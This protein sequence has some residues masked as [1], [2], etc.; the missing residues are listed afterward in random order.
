MAAP[1]HDYTIQGDYTVT[2]VVT[3]PTGKTGSATQLIEATNISIDGLSVQYKC[4]DQSSSSG[5]VRAEYRIVNNSNQNLPIN[6]FKIRYWFTKDGAT[7]QN[8]FC[9]Y[10]QVGSGNISGSF[11]NMSPTTVNADNYLE[12]SISGTSTLNA[13]SNSGQIQTRF[14]KSDWQAYTQTNDYS[15]DATALSFTENTKVTLY[16]DGELVFGEE[17]GAVGNNAPVAVISPSVLSGIAPL[18]VTFN[19]SGSS[20][21]DSDPITYLW[22]SGETTSG[23]S[24]TYTTAGTYNVSLTVSDG[25]LTNQTSVSVVVTSVPV[26]VTGVSVNPI[27]LN[28]TPGQ[29]GSVIATV[30]PANA[31]N[32]TVVWTS[33]NTAAATVNQ[34]GVVTAV[35]NGNAIITVTT[36]DGGF[37]ATCNVLVETQIV[38][39]T[40][41]TVNPSSASI[42]EGSSEQLAATV[43]PGNAT[44]KSVTWTSSNPAAATVSQSGLVTAVAEGSAII[45]AT[46]VDGNFTDNCNVTVTPAGG[47][48]FGVPQASPL[49]SMNKEYTYLHVIGNGP[50]L[51]NV[52]KFNINW[53]LPNNGLWQMS[54]NTNN[55]QPNWYVDLRTSAT[56]SLN[57]ANP[58]I[59]FSGSGFSG[60]DGN[61]WV[62]IDGANL[63]LV[64]KTG[65]YTIYFSSS[66][67]DPC[68]AK[69]ATIATS[70]AKQ[71]LE[72]VSIRPNPASDQL[73][74]TGL[75]HVSKIE[76]V[77]IL[78]QLKY[79]NAVDNAK[80]N[81]NT[82]EFQ[83]GT[84]IINL[85]LNTGEIINKKLMVK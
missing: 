4:N 36:N 2:L 23:I 7:A 37:Q 62:T 56:Y 39:V 6:K 64:E 26:S 46:S 35:A 13:G 22:N 40:S 78:G 8:F 59:S 28:L 17:P 11:T 85:Y 31:T 66:A 65:A 47:C 48:S 20:D 53:D 42:L 75:E 71:V 57:T 52:T 80:M 29:T 34:S 72:N 19:G 81:I 33:S 44:N 18:T 3:D 5:N 49:A 41:V 60:L 73:T 9:D 69:S 21:P 54:V 12:I 58:E 16:Y 74:I 50:N 45:T 38:H 51:N 68:G 63:V 67:A 1:T 82:N 61:Y 43:L 10:A 83:Q 76:I 32:K 77:N 25:S 24:K 79:S 14:A 84:Y 15:F 55:G 27:G 30:T 70:I